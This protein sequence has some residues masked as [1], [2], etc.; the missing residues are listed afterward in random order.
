[1]TLHTAFI[2]K[3][4]LAF[5]FAID[6]IP[7][8]IVLGTAIVLSFLYKL[9]PPNESPQIKFSTLH[10]KGS[11]TWASRW[12]NLPKLLLLGSLATLALAWVDPRFY[13]EK[14]EASS[15]ERAPFMPDQQPVEGL[16]IYFI[17]DQSGS[18]REA[19]PTVRRQSEVKIDLLKDVTKQFIIGNRTSGLPGRP[20]DMIGLVSFARGANVLSPLTLDHQAVLQELENLAHVASRD[21]DGTSI[22]YAI[23]KTANMI[24][25][26]RH[27]AEGLEAKGEPAYSIKNSVMILVTDGIQDPNP[28]DKG[29]R[30][31]NIDV[32]EAAAYAKEQGIKLYIINVDP[33]LATEEFAPYRRM[34]Q[35]AA[36]TTGGKFFMVD[37]SSNLDRIYKEIDTL[38]KSILPVS[39]AT[40]TDPANR[41]DRYTRISL[42]PYFI[43]LGLLFL[44]ASIV[45]QT[46]MLRRTP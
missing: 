45:L 33:K 14:T 15:F 41:P 11:E 3:T 6:W 17:L 36:E 1:M 38:E 24:A 28:L 10:F 27:Y 2:Q 21:Q 4:V 5:T 37:Q 40:S 29:K 34:M 19:V 46:T 22:G 23:F 25:A 7:F 20:N 32:P 42:Y 31:R 13:I 39:A 30:L 8:L 16:A 44:L 26:T 18:M 12:Y 43:A 9:V 35:R